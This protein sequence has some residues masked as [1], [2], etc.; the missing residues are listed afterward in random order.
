M[1]L[2]NANS[3]AQSR[4]KNKPVIVKFHKEHVIGK[5]FT[6]FTASP[7]NGLTNTC[8]HKPSYNFTLAG[9]GVT[10]Y[11]DGS[12]TYPAPGDK[13]YKKPH[14]N[15]RYLVDIG[16]YHILDGT[17]HKNI[18]VLSASKTSKDTQVALVT[19]CQ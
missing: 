11:H 17:T 14:A 7:N 4:G 1:A 15:P 13:M 6:A 12:G 8:I 5:G 3:S 16:N 18:T 19:T 9:T 2:G 10:Y